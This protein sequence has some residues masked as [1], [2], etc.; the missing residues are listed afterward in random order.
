M[1][2]FFGSVQTRDN[3]SRGKLAML[4]IDRFLFF[5]LL[6]GLYYCLEALV[7]SYIRLQEDIETLEKIQK[8]RSVFL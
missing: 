8:K 1:Y 6:I 3:K 2:S 5:L 7:I 4:Q